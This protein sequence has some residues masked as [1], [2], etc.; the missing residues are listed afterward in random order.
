MPLF[1]VDHISA[2]NAG[3]CSTAA[4]SA[5]TTAQLSELWEA[6]LAALQRAT[7][8][9]CGPGSYDSHLHKSIRHETKKKFERM[10]RAASSDSRQ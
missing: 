3:A 5:V 7:E 1:A 4:G 10:S 9:I 2:S 6:Q 8:P